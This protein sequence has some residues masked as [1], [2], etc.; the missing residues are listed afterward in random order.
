MAWDKF[1]AFIRV[2]V[3]GSSVLMYVYEWVGK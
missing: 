3:V 2:W 1:N